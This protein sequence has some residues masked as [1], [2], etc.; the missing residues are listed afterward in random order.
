MLT[1]IL[2]V[3]ATTSLLVGSVLSFDQ[4]YL[5]DY[6]YLIGTSLFF[7][8]ASINLSLEIYKKR[9]NALDVYHMIN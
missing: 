4:D 6:F 5:S 8:K 9:K 3:S 7:I 1:N 2:Y